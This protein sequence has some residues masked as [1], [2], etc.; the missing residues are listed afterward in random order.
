MGSSPPPPSQAALPASKA[1]ILVVE[2]EFL[3]RLLVSEELRLAGYHVIEAMDADEAV[4]VL[5]SGVRVD[6]IL[7]DVR[8]PGT[9]DGLGLLAFVRA[10]YPMVPMIIT[11]GHLQRDTTFDDGTAYLPK[12]YTLPQAVTLV[13]AQLEN[14]K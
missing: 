7:S 3:I 10:S 14:R 2:D 8:M 13:Q 9:L 4:S 6:L 12:P 11:S 5:K 1:F